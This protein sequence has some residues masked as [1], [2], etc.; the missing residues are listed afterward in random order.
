MS[1]IDTSTL[2]AKPKEKYGLTNWS[3]YNAGYPN[4]GLSPPC[5]WLGSCS[6]VTPPIRKPFRASLPVPAGDAVPAGR[7]SGVNDALGTIRPHCCP[8]EWSHSYRNPTPDPKPP[9]LG[10]P[11][12]GS[13][14]P[15]ASLLPSGSFPSLPGHTHWRV[16]AVPQPA[17]PILFVPLSPKI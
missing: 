11:G 1:K 5:V 4:S 10:Q 16:W 2:P 17:A 7:P 9:P 12:P 14:R 8:E 6:W 3:A 15:I 13:D